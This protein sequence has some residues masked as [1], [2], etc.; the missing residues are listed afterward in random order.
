VW[1]QAARP[2]FS[3]VLVNPDRSSTL[4]VPRA[5]EAPEG[6]TT[7]LRA[8]RR[9]SRE[10]SDAVAPPAPL[11]MPPMVLG[12]NLMGMAPIAGA[13][14]IEM[15][16]DLRAVVGSRPGVLVLRVADGT[17]ASEA[18]LRSGDVIVSAGGVAVRSPLVLSRLL[19]R[20]DDDRAV[21]LRVERKGKAREVVL[22]W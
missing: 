3:F 9:P 5:A 8:T 15:D 1:T 6:G 13:Q 14:L 4:T 20:S 19:M 2:G 18:G 11:A 22:R 21:P 7:R 10:R 16:E 12:L 17:P